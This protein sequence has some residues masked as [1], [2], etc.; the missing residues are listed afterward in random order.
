MIL[1]IIGAGYI[2][3]Y[4]G[5]ELLSQKHRIVV[6]NN[7]ST[8]HRESFDRKVSFEKGDLHNSAD[9]ETVS[10]RYSIGAVM[11]FACVITSLN[12]R[13][14]QCTLLKVIL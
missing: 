13:I 11:M 1:V 7:L 14:I 10:L 9:L 2:G 12:Y 6:L 3:S 4:V 5:K 8:G